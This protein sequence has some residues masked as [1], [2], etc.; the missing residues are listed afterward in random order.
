MQGNRSSE[1]S[2]LDAIECKM[3]LSKLQTTEKLVKY[4]KYN[5]KIA[6]VQEWTP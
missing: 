3:K 4:R 2:K 5:T 1:A 6:S